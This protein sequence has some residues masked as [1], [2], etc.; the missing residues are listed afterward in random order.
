M[1][2][3]L[4]QNY[5]KAFWGSL[6][7]HPESQAMMSS[8]QEIGEAFKS[9]EIVSYFSSPVFSSEQKLKTVETVLKDKI[10]SELFATIRLLAENDRLSFLPQIF[11]SMVSLK[12]DSM[13]VKQGTIYSAVELSKEEVQKIE[14]VVGAKISSK[15]LL[16]LKIDNKI[17]AGV[18]VEVDGWTFD[19]GLDYH[20][21][22]L[23]EYLKRS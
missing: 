2:K 7:G 10:P 6:A 16:N 15:V 14:L 19:D 21:L 3:T 9:D 8:L 17:K 12:N 1:S 18:R 13:G 5:A 11:E 4:V 23:T 20:E 22:K